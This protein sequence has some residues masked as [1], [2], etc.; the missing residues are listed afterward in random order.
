MSSIS[1]EWTLLE[2]AN[3]SEW[4]HGNNNAT[5]EILWTHASEENEMKHELQDVSYID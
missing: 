1:A 5:F 4:T 3:T 2:H